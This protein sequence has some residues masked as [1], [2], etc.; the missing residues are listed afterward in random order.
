[1][2]Y[3]CPYFIQWANK[4]LLINTLIKVELPEKMI[5]SMILLV[6]LS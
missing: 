2:P 6:T 3:I 5:V 1:M 4:E